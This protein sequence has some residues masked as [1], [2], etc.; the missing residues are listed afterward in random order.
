MLILRVSPRAPKSESVCKWCYCLV[1]IKMP[2]HVIAHKYPQVF[3]ALRSVE[4]SHRSVPTGD[5]RLGGVLSQPALPSSFL[6]RTANQPNPVLGHLLAWRGSTR[7]EQA[8]FYSWSH[9][10][11]QGVLREELFPWAK[12]ANGQVL[13]I[14]Y[15]PSS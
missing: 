8:E 1:E 3:A 12:K 15:L 10:G 11:P 9:P 2:P 4:G 13:Y 14:H 6:L 5:V 7:V